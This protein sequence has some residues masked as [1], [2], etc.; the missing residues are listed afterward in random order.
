MINTNH[1]SN[2]ANMTRH[3]RP[4]GALALAAVIAVISL[5]FGSS[6]RSEAGTVTGA[7]NGPT[8]KHKKHK[9]VLPSSQVAPGTL[10]PLSPG[11]PPSPGAPGTLPPLP[12]TDSASS[13]SLPGTLPSPSLG[14]APGRTL[15]GA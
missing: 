14:S 8:H 5:G 6:D 3:L 4:L 1:H 12:S 15:P 7:A 2:G 13:R 9:R 11:S 10:P